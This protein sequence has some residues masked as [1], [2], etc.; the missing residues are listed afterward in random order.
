MGVV[1]AVDDDSDFLNSV[2]RLLRAYG[3]EVRA[4]SS[5]E[6]LQQHDD[7]DSGACFLLDVH[8]PGM[9]GIELCRIM[10]RQGVSAPVVFMTGR[11]DPAIRRAAE[12]QGCL[13]YMRKPFDDDRLIDAITQAVRR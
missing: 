13:A 7:L 6:A 1:F 4:F 10:R 3:F 5:A 12:E 8:L 11:D 9:S 2:A